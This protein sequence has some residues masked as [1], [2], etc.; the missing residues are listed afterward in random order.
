MTVASYILQPEHIE[1]IRE[2]GGPLAEV[3]D[4]STLAQKSSICVVEMDGQ[5]VAYWAVFYALH[6]EP[7]WVTESRRKSP[8]VIRALLRQLEQLLDHIGDP[9]GFAI[10]GQDDVL[11]QGAQ[12]V[13]RLGFEPVPGTLYYLVR[14]PPKEAP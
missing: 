9:I 8:A 1:R 12:Y 7:M 13:E 6:A 11:E 10:I 2:A 4:L 14:Q 3:S 5:I